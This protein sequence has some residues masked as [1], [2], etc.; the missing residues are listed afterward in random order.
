VDWGLRGLEG[1]LADSGNWM[2]GARVR[3]TGEVGERGKGWGRVVEIECRS[4]GQ[5]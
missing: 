1:Y 3:G 2:G 5:W 4:E